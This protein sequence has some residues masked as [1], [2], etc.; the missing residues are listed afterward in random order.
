MNAVFKASLL[1]LLLLIA[2]S[3]LAYADNLPAPLMNDPRLSFLSTSTS[4]NISLMYNPETVTDIGGL[5]N[6]AKDVHDEIAEFFGGYPYRTTV[7]V[8]GTNSEFRLVIKVGDAPDTAKALNWNVGYNGLIISKSPT[9]L[10][11]FKK[12]LKHQMARI[13]VRT[14][15]EHY[16]SL[17]EWYQD[18]MASCIAGDLTPEQR[19]TVSLKAVSGQWMSLEDIERAYRNMTIYNYDEQENLDARTQAAMLV[20][21]MGEQFGDRTLVEI[22]DDYTESGNLTQAFLNKTAFTPDTLNTAFRDVRSGNAS[23][24]PDP[25]AGVTSTAKPGNVTKPTSSPTAVPRVQDSLNASGTVPGETAGWSLPPTRDIL[26]YGS[27]AVVNAIG[28]IAV[29]IILRRNWH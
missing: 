6:T 2:L 1:A 21:Y 27:I 29:L 23:A 11:D 4:E 22:I 7:A 28:I 13:A 26:L 19:M 24:S 12:T 14:R 16:K 3:S 8:V 18:G 5:M 17:P 9:L 10:S 25:S 15:Q 20:D